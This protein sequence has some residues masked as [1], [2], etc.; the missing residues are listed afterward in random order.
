MKKILVPL[1]FMLL[2]AGCGS[3]QP[4]ATAN[5]TPTPQPMTASPAPTPTPTNGPVKTFNVSGQNY[6]F[7]PS[8]ISVNKGDTVKITFTNNGGWPHNFALDEFNVKSQTVQVGQSDTVQFVADK[9]G[10]F[11]FYCSVANHKAMGMVGTLTVK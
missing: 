1:A 8:T 9:A 3:S 10:S 4:A 5:P 11:Q 6:S 7:S 2:A